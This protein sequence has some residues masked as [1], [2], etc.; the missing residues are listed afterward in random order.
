MGDVSDSDSGGKDVDSDS[1]KSDDEG[2]RS[3]SKSS[4]DSSD[5]EGCV[6]QFEDWDNG[7]ELTEVE[8][9]DVMALRSNCERSCA[10]NIRKR[11]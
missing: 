4:D 2:A 5:N 7:E 8:R 10:M 3:D 1:I 6:D 9:R 11:Q